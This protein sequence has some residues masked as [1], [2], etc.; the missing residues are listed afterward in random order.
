MTRCD[1]YYDRTAEFDR[2]PA[3]CSTDTVMLGDSLTCFGGNWNQR[4]LGQSTGPFVNRGIAGDDTDG[5]YDRL[6]QVLPFHPARIIFLAG[7]NDISH[8]LTAQEVAGG[9]LRICHAIRRECP[10]TLLTL[11]TLLPFNEQFHRWRLLEGRSDV[12]VEVN[13]Q[14]RETAQ[15]E[16]IDL[17]DLYPHFCEPDGNQLPAHLTVDGLHLT[18]AGYAIWV[19]LLRGHLH[20]PPVAGHAPQS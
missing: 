6:N 17:L 19:E 1:T 10:D 18:E 7:V 12:V 9:V 13:R 20:L 4:L 16:G 11:Q 3:I 5:I 15:K 14:L 8:G 2:E